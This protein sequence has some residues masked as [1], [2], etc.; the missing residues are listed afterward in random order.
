MADY[1][2]NQEQFWAGEFGD[3]YA[4]RNRGAAWI[5]SNSALFERI[6]DCTEGVESVLE[7]DQRARRLAR[8]LVKAQE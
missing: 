2:T 5:E 7:A 1:S 8:E 6:L 3:A 4:E